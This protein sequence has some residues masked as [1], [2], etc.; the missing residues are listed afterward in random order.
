MKR[1]SLSESTHARNEARGCATHTEYVPGTTI[2]TDL[3]TV[4]IITVPVHY[5][6]IGDAS[7]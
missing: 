7:F 4:R 2:L 6:I 3:V 1:D 5:A